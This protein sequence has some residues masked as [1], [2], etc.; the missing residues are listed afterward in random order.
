MCSLQRQA[1]QFIVY[2]CSTLLTVFTMELLEVKA[3][4]LECLKIFTTTCAQNLLSK[5]VPCCLSQNALSTSTNNSNKRCQF[6]ELLSSCIGK[7]ARKQIRQ[8]D[9]GRKTSQNYEISR[10]LFG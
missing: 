3:T 9:G 1:L 7:V 6:P 4:F 8:A 10:Y 2:V 5:V